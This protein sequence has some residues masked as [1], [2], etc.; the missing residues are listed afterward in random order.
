MTEIGS[1]DW[2]EQQRARVE[3]M[4]IAPDLRLVLQ[5]TI[6]GEVGRSWHVTVADGGA[7]VTAGPHPDPDVTLSAD[8]ST[9]DAI[10]SG[11]SS[12]RREFLDGRLRIAGDITL[13][14]AA[15]DAFAI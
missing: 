7:T 11:R 14:L 6:T 13:L 3:S 4:E 8:P 15:R 2:I 9:V 1:P 12:A 10:A 5:H